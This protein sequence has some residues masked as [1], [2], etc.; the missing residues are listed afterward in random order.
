M[1][2]TY[3]LALYLTQ[4]PI[5]MK[6]NLLILM[7]LFTAVIGYSQTVGDTFVE[8][9]QFFTITSLNPN[10]VQVYNYI[11]SA[12]SVV[13][14]PSAVTN[15]GNTY[16]VTRID[17][18]AF[19]DK[20]LTDVTIP[21]SVE[22]M[23]TGAFY[24]N[25]LT[26]IT[27]PNSITDIGFAAFLG[28]SLLTCIISEATTPPTIT[29]SGSVD[30]FATDRSNINLSIPSGTA[31]AYTSAGWTDFNSVAEGLT[32]TFVVDNITYQINPTPNNEVTVTDYNAA[33]GT[34]VTIPATVSSA[35]TSFSVVSIG[36]SAF[37][38]KSLTSVTIPNSV[39]II[40]NEAFRDNNL[41]TI[42]I[43]DSVTII[44]DSAFAENQ[45]NNV[46]LLDGLITI[47]EYAFG[48]N[49]LT[50]ISI[51]NSVTDIG[52]Y[53]F[54]YNVLT[55][56]TIS[57]SVISI[58]GGA[59]F[60]NTLTDVTSL[61]TIPPT[62]FT[63]GNDTFGVNNRPNI[64]LHIPP[65]TLATYVTDA[66]ALWTD[67]NPV[68]EDAALSRSNFEL[69]NDIKI[70]SIT[71]KVEIKHSNKIK[72]QHY[73]IYSISGAKIKAGKEST[74]N[75]NTLSNGIYILELNFNTGRLVKKFA[76]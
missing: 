51:P 9:S 42:S 62:I 72:L 37:N 19:A 27:I 28:N 8:D 7:T 66:G 58:G 55:N 47:G 71:D 67:F 23:G 59:F 3:T 74:I 30:T 54:L 50:N 14:I 11:A 31:S 16:S 39:I 43:P 46:A 76:K 53:A 32:G 34:D 56:V 48:V 26:T 15:A 41:M 22:T 18:N 29:T 21:N 64:H 65:G 35:C 6:K 75:I 5:N 1:L 20:G 61:A 4:K 49:Q 70:I 13:N 69:A 10:T 44:G 36:A 68:T 40:S 38:G 24:G 33:G 57:S 25:Q 45:L 17:V 63:G 73:S 2:C 12:G 52:D 60:N